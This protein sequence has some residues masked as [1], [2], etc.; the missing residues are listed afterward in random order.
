M[1]LIIIRQEID[2]DQIWEARFK[3]CLIDSENELFALY[4]YIEVTPVVFI[5]KQ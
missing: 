1:Y 2:Q 5:K 3:S 4:R